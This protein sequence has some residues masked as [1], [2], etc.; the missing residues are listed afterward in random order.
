MTPKQKAKELV[1]KFIK[2]ADKGAQLK[3]NEHTGRTGIF[4]PAYRSEYNAKQCAT[5]AVDEILDVLGNVGVYSFADPKVTA[6]WE[7]VKAE[8]ENL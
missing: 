3:T 5:I 1:E 2:Y 6:Y 7:D 4:I 8:I